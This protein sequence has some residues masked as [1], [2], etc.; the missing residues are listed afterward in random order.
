MMLLPAQDTRKHSEF[1]SL[2]TLDFW[3]RSY[4][5]KCGS[6][7]CGSSVPFSYFLGQDWFCES[8]IGVGPNGNSLLGQD[9]R[10]MV[11]PIEFIQKV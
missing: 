6:H 11:D 9:T 1:V 4:P 3:N 5:M 8:S 10:E 2:P 7:A